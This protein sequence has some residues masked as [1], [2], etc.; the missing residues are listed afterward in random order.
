MFFR[1][2]R[3]L[4]VSIFVQ[5]SQERR[6]ISSSL[7]PMVC[8]PTLFF[9]ET[10]NLIFTV[11]IMVSIFSNAMSNSSFGLLDVKA[12]QIRDAVAK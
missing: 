8:F 7:F 4:I 10:L 3:S 6:A 11:L 5:L 12:F 1:P 9:D 2:I